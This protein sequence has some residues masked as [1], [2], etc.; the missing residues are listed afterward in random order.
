MILAFAVMLACLGL[1]RAMASAEGRTLERLGWSA[2]AGV[3]VGLGLVTKGPY[4]L[5]FPA[6][7]VWLA[8][9][10]AKGLKR[11]GPRSAFVVVVCALAVIACWAVPAFLRDGGG[12]LG[13][14]VF[15]PDLTSGSSHHARAFYWYLGPLLA[16]SMPFT[17]F[18]PWIVKD[19]RRRGWSAAL[20]VALA[21]LLAL[22]AVPGKR[23]HYLLPVTPFLALAMAEALVRSMA[24]RAWLRRLAGWSVVIGLAI[25]PTYY[26]VVSA[27]THPPEDGS[28]A[29]ARE[30]IETIGPRARVVATR[31]ISERLAFVGR[32][33]DILEAPGAEGA[34]DILRSGPPEPTYLALEAPEVAPVIAACSD[35]WEFRDLGTSGLSKRGRYVFALYWTTPIA[36]AVRGSDD[37]LAQRRRT[38]NEARYNAR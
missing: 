1:A 34:I 17:I 16:T 18:L 12:Y 24:D 10:R 37:T 4:G 9:L 23:A 35:A 6:L 29:F 5:L 20:L 38:R 21:M 30:A 32:R 22:S 19:V 8:P 33:S 31:R 2:L 36:G 27:I 15:Q 26:G 28:L 3:G 14:V 7:F 11:P 13:R 25:A